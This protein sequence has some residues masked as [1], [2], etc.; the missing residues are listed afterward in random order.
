MIR[1]QKL[2]VK[3]SRKERKRW[4]INP[5]T[6]VHGETGYKRSRQKEKNREKLKEEREEREVERGK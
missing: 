5:R 2:K 3:V 4:F 1:R 6:R